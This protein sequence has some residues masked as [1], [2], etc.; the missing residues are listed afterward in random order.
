MTEFAVRYADVLDVPSD[1]LLLKHAQGFYGAD[2]AVASRLISASV[3]TRSQ[4][5]PRPGASVIIDTKGTMA[6]KRRVFVAMPFSEEFE[7]VYEFGIYPA[8]RDCGCICE[9]VDETLFFG[10]V[11]TQIRKG[12]ETADLVI[13]DLSD[14]RPNVYLEVGYA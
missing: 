11:L 3:C 7:N 1:L 2:A 9:R 12:I 6:P 13:A 10:D 5:Q 8:V 4:L 14:G